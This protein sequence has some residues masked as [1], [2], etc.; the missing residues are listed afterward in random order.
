M[1]NNITNDERLQDKFPWAEKKSKNVVL[2]DTYNRINYF[3]YAKRVMCC[4]QHLFF[5]VPAESLPHE[6]ADKLVLHQAMFCKVRLCPMCQKR[7]SLKVFTQVSKVM[8]ICQ[9]RHADLRPVF[10]TLTVENCSGDELDA[11]IRHILKSWYRLTNHRRFD[12]QV[13][14]WFR[15]LEV[16]YNKDTDSYHPHIH[17]ILM[18]DKMYFNSSNKKYID[19][20]EWRRLWAVSAR[21]D[22]DPWVDIRKVRKNRENMAKTVAE[23]AKYA[24]KD[25]DFV[26]N[27]GVTK[28]FTDALHRKRLFAFGGVL[29]DIAKEIKA[30]KPDEGDL[31]HID[32]TV[33]EDVATVIIRYDWSFGVGDYIR[34]R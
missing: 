3:A 23:V 25:T 11:T 7:R 5:R 34:K 22:Y 16:T 14:G 30:E 8:N 19:Q 26:G 29:H 21:L 2:A 6:P 31:V 24:V 15:A 18:V 27:D 20:L 4:A 9:V 1:A 17:A 10:L 33:R 32:D 12:E 13:K 28:V